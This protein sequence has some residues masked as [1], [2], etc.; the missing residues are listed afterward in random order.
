M[1]ADIAQPSAGQPGWGLIFL[2]GVALNIVAGFLNWHAVLHGTLS[3][4]DSYM[5]L[6]RIWQGIQAG[7]LTNMVARDDSG[8]GVLVEWSRLLDALLLVMAAPLAPWLGWKSALFVAGVAFGPIAVGLLGLSIAFAAAP[9]AARKFLVLAP[10]AAVLMPALAN[11]ALPGVVTHHV[12][13]LVPIAFCA[14]CLVRARTGARL[15]AWLAGIAGGIAIWITPETMP[16]ILLLFGGFFLVWL[17]NQAAP[18]G[19][20]GRAFALMLLAAC[21]IDPPHG[22]WLTPEIDRLSI[23]YAALGVDV[24]LL[25]WA[26]GR[27]GPRPVVA[28]PLGGLCILA[29]LALF[30]KV[31]LGPFGLMSPADAKRFFGPI[32]EMQPIHTWPMAVEFLLPGVVALIYAGLSWQRRKHWIWLYTMAALI[33]A[34]ILALRFARFSPFSSLMAAGLLPVML[35]DITNALGE[36]TL[37]AML[38]RI[39]LVALMVVAPRL[40]VFVPAGHPSPANHLTPCDLSLFSKNLA[41]YAGYI[42]LADVN[43]TPELLW[44]TN[45]ITVGSLY[46]NGIAGFLRLRAAWRAPAGT[47]IP[48]AFRATRAQLVLV[49][50]AAGHSLLVQGAPDDSLLDSI[51]AGHPPPWLKRIE[52]PTPGGYDLYRVAGG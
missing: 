38:S 21:L 8:A 33:F 18:I 10:I 42:V 26:L 27:I 19:V 35:T 43:D 13:L 5:R 6:E 30:P 45:I 4:P 34:L 14:G 51:L 9:F 47:Q 24:A 40:A 48:P 2:L 17:G 36:D 12:I 49:C 28:I 20:V 39:A 37:G 15:P 16:F 50:P 41:P 7:H 11:Y 1:S 44:R 32:I 46:Q 23:V 22:G 25:T 31:A 29:W 52:P 3:D